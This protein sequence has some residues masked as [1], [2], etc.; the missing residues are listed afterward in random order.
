[1]RR[2]EAFKRGPTSFNQVCKR[3]RVCVCVSAH[4]AVFVAANAL[5]KTFWVVRIYL[6][7]RVVSTEAKV[8]QRL[9]EFTCDGK[10]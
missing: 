8:R 5:R 3:A 7:M 6:H 1:M 9:E 4:I 2:G 10:D